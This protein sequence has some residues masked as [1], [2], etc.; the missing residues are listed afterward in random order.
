MVRFLDDV[1]L[2]AGWKKQRMIRI[3]KRWSLR[4]RIRVLDYSGDGWYEK[5][6]RI[7]VYA[8]RA[9]GCHRY[10]RTVDGNI[11]AGASKGQK[12]SEVSRLS[13]KLE[14]VGCYTLHV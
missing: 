8:D 2:I 9:L 3:V 4:T 13:V 6:H 14:T 10:H 1:E 5:A 11:V 7:G 12:A